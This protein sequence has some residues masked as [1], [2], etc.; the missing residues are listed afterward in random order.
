MTTNYKIQLRTT[1][2]EY[3]S[4]TNPTIYQFVAI[5]GS[6]GRS[7]IPALNLKRK[8][9]FRY[10]KHGIQEFHGKYVLVS[11]DKAANNVGVVCRLHYN[12]I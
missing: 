4:A 9:S 5:R 10:L 6:S 11:A 1:R 7:G 12:N 2:I 3:D 8:S